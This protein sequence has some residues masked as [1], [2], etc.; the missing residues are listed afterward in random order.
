MP[1]QGKHSGSVDHPHRSGHTLGDTHGF[2]ESIDES[3][4]RIEVT[5]QGVVP[6]LCAQRDVCPLPSLAFVQDRSQ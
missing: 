1:Q 3:R 6:L 5:L 2:L 4:T